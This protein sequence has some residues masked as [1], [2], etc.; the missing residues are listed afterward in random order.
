M[1]SNPFGQAGKNTKRIGI[2]LP[3]TPRRTRIQLGHIGYPSDTNP[4]PPPSP[5][6]PPHRSPIRTTPALSQSLRQL[7]I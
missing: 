3:C 4:S 2:S 6:P 7:T 5:P 1:I